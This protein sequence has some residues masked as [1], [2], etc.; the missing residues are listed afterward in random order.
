MPGKVF[1][2]AN[3]PIAF[4]NVEQLMQILRGD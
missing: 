2:F 1:A 3:I 4:A